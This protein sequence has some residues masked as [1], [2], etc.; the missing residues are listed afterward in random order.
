MGIFWVFGIIR[1]ISRIREYEINV[2]TLDYF[3]IS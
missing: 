2:K 1:G 3:L